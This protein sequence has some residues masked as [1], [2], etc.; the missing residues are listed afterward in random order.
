[1]GGKMGWQDLRPPDTLSPGR[2]KGGSLT[3]E[4]GLFGGD[5]LFFSLLIGAD[6]PR[7]VFGDAFF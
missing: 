6:W 7:P 5:F 4:G 1:M 3:F 2:E